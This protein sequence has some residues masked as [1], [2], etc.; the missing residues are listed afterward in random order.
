MFFEVFFGVARLLAASVL[1][2]YFV[3]L[4]VFPRKTEIDLIER[5]LFSIVFSITLV[6]FL[7]FAE[8]T[9]FQIPINFFSILLNAIFIAL[10]SLFLYFA[11]IGVVPV[12][13]FFEKF[14]GKI[15][16]EEA[17]GFP[18]PFKK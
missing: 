15:E 8:N 16:R 2:G 14:F 7:A 6:P 9:F 13:K 1:I 3:S 17:M 18:L 11:R 12:P 4:A 10:F 5:M